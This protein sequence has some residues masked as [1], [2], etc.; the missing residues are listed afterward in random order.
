MGRFVLP[1]RWEWADQYFL[2]PRGDR[3]KTLIV[4]VFMYPK[5]WLKLVMN[6]FNRKCIKMDIMFEE[7]TSEFCLIHNLAY[8]LVWFTWLSIHIQNS[9][10][11]FSKTGF[12]AMQILESQLLHK[13]FSQNHILE[14]FCCLQ[15]FVL[16]GKEYL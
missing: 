5:I 12:F 6:Y 3:C 4:V 16:R 1:L 14:E 8:H 13:S 10:R 15:E 7:M 11:V 2:L 9:K